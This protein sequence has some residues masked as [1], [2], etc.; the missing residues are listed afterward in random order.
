MWLNLNPGRMFSIETK[1]QRIDET[2]DFYIYT[3]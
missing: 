2:K 3:S 1:W